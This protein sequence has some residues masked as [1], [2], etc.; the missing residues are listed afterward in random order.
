MGGG[1]ATNPHGRSLAYPAPVTSGEVENVSF[2]PQLAYQCGPASLAGVLNFYGKDVTPD[3]VA[4]E[5]FRSG[6]GG[7]V[8]LDMVLYVRKKGLFANWYNG[9]GEDI[10][11]A[12]DADVP[13][14][15]MVDFGFG[16][17][18][19]YHYMVVIGYGPEGIIAN[20]GQEQK[21]EI[22]WKQFFSRWD[23][24]KRWTLRI[25]PKISKSDHKSK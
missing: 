6:I 1:C 19:K 9:S 25:E 13:L 18:S 10:Q 23:R 21:K 22:K 24:T 16:N 8:P 4:R 14:I 11:R 15:V 5:I 2:Y 12:V 7:T 20:T 17:I 3:Q